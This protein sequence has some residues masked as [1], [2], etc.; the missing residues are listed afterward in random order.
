MAE[1]IT[2]ENTQPGN[3]GGEKEPT[4]V[5]DRIKDLTD[6]LGEKDRV[7]NLEKEQLL[8]EKQQAEKTAK[9]AQ[10]K[11]DLLEQSS[12]YPL[13]QEHA[14]EIRSYSEKGLSVDEAT[15]LVLQKNNKLV[16][17]EDIDKGKF[18]PSSFGGSSVNAKPTGEKDI[19]QMTQEERREELKEREEKGE[20][21]ATQ[22]GKLYIK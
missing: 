10:F 7:H 4:R 6:K 15:I 11:A 12:K 22:D 19:S 17:K 9:D 8:K 18:E 5:E 14:D 13:A 2:K 16:S 1:E 21:G 20:W 3:A